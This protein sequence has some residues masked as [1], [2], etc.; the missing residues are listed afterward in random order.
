MENSNNYTS[1]ELAKCPYHAQLAQEQN[2]DEREEANT[3]DWDD[4][5]DEDGTDPNRY[6]EEDGNNN[7]GGAGSSGSAATNS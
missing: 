2:N 7:S 5:R 3:G 4:Q 1:E 6:E